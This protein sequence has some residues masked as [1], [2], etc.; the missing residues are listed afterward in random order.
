MAH[1]TGGGLVENIP[2]ILPEGCAA[3]LEKNRWDVPKIFR[4]IQDT[5]RIADQEMFHVFNMGIGMVLVVSKSDVKTVL[6][7]LEKAKEP[8]TIIGD[9]I[10]GDRIVHIV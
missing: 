8:G 4:I 10:K 5:G 7:D 3:T 2:R 9:V 1:I 6:S